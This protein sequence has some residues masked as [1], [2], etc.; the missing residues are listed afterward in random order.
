M[1]EEESIGKKFGEGSSPVCK[2]I[3]RK[4]F[5]FVVIGS[6]RARA[7]KP[8]M[9]RFLKALHT[10]RALVLCALIVAQGK[11]VRARTRPFPA[12]SHHYLLRSDVVF[13]STSL[14]SASSMLRSSPHTVKVFTYFGGG[15]YVHTRISSRIPSKCIVKKSRKE[16]KN[17][18]IA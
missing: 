16:C 8:L 14:S 18:G 1:G 11:K 15:E 3:R 4:P 6:I 13:F 12:R 17:F 10:T 2:S 7:R 9:N 5:A